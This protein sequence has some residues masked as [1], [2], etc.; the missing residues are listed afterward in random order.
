MIVFKPTIGKVTTA[1]AILAARP[2]GGY[3]SLEA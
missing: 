2:D 3:E 1:N